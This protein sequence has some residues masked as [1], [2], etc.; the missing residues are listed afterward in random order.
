[1]PLRTLLLAAVLSLCG[2]VGGERIA[3]DAKSPP[4]S[5]DSPLKPA[6]LAVSDDRDEVKRFEKKEWFLGDAPAGDRDLSN[7]QLVPLHSQMRGDLADELKS[8]G[9]DVVAENDV[10]K[11]TISVR[12]WYFD[13]T[14]R[15]LRYRIEAKVLQSADGKMLA[16][17]MLQEDEPIGGAD[18]K[19]TKA[20]LN[21]AYG[22]MIHRLVRENP[23]VLAALRR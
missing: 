2:C 16:E 13:A 19:S 23:T 10:P 11:L 20:D 9:F 8:L 17:S 5:K 15:K 18:D 14:T 22:A 12:D 7:R 1:M 4:P 3:L 21:R 6:A